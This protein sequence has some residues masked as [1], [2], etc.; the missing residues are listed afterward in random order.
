MSRRAPGM[1]LGLALIAS[2]GCNPFRSGSV[3]G[4]VEAKGELGNWVLEKGNCYSGQREQYFGVIGFG[5]DGSGIAIKLVKDGVR[6]W[7]AIVNQASSCRNEAEKGG[8]KAVV[9]APND[10]T[11]FD[12]DVTRTNTT[13]ND[14]RA[15]DGT[16]HIECSNDTSSVKGNLTFDHCH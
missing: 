11:T 3:K 2:V 10:C 5:P 16:L 9:F 12:V 13:V 15:L 7:T 6:G 1:V 8:C 4:H 14:I